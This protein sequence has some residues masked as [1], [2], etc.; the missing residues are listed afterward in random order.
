MNF[1]CQF[2]FVLRDVL[3]SLNKLF[4]FGDAFS[5]GKLDLSKLPEQ[6]P[7]EFKDRMKNADKDGDGFLSGDELEAARPQGP[8]FGGGMRGGRRGAPSESENK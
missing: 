2:R 6:L 8:G 7:Q 3:R 4:F 5:D 1:A